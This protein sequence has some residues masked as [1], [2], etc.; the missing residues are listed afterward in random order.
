MDGYSVLFCRHLRWTT[1][2]FIY[3]YKII[4][5]TSINIGIE[6]KFPR[7]NNRSKRG[8]LLLGILNNDQS[9]KDHLTRTEANFINVENSQTIISIKGK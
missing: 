5:L 8:V 4:Y 9:F 3:L 7:K 6:S 2:S 1:S